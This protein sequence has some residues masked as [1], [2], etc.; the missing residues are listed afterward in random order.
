MTVIL[1]GSARA[2]ARSWQEHRKTVKADRRYLV[3][4]TIPRMLNRKQSHHSIDAGRNQE[5]ELA[6]PLEIGGSV[7]RSPD[8]DSC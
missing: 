3:I 1:C 4:V 8:L 5:S 2:L 7:S 6:R